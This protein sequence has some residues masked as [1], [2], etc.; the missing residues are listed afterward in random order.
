MAIRSW[1]PLALLAL[2]SAAAHAAATCT[3]SALREHPPA[4]NFRVDNDLF[5]GRHQDQGYTNGALLT[6]VSPN[7]RDYTDDPCLPAPARWLNRR[8]ERLHPGRFEQQNMIVSIGQ[9]LFTPTDR[10][11]ADLI[12]D[13]RPYAAALLANFGYNARTGNQLRTTQLALGVVGPAAQGKQVQDAVHRLLHDEKFKG[14]QHQLHNEPVFR[15]LHE[16]MWR[17][18]ARTP[19]GWSWDAI[20]HGGAALGNLTTHGNAGGELRAGWK[21]P[22]DFGSS[23]MRPAGENTA[24]TR[25][26][27]LPGWSGHLFLTADARWVLRDITLDGNT[28]RRSHRVD[29]RHVVGDLGYGVALI[30]GRWKFALARYHRSREFE[31]QRERPVFGSF[32]LSRTL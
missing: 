15:L 11:R 13:D 18:P 4:V 27:R 19:A 29:K 10:S 7:L 14:W 30:H 5:G 8:L 17:R 22:D 31:G 28:F 12:E 23:P 1:L 9:G 6:L 3:G 24:P 16:R 2:P 32:T 26:G 21:L 25:G 20:G